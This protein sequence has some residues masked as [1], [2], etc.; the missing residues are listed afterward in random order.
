[1]LAAGA[2]DVA[3]GIE[4]AVD[5]VADHAAVAGQRRRLLDQRRG[6]RVADVGEIV[7][8]PDQALDERR[9]H[10]L[11]HEPD[12]RDRGER[13][14]QRDQVARPGRANRHPADEP[15][16]VVDGAQRVAQ[17]AALGGLERE[18]LDRVEPILDPLERRQR[19]HQPGA[20]AAC[21]HD[22]L[23]PIEHRQQRSVAA[24][25]RAFE[26]L[27]VP[28][29]HR[30]DEQAVLP[31]APADGP[32]VGEVDL[33][34]IAQIFD[35]RPGGAD[36]GRVAV[37]A[38]GVQAAG[39]QLIAQ[40][41]GGA[42][43]AEGPLVERR[44]GDAEAGD[45]GQQRHRLD[46]LRHDDLAGPQHAELLVER[47]PAVGA[48]IL[49][50]Q[51]LAGRGVE[52]SHPEEVA[53]AGCEGEQEGRLTGIEIAGVG[54]GPRRDDAGHVALDDALGLLRILDLVADGDPEAALTSRVM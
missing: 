31:L 23:G 44:H 11:E 7:Q 49:G 17:A 4:I 25:F 22:G 40:R 19:A 32:D 39:P 47:L 34:R 41:L 18:L 5:A 2:A 45:L 3:Q 21:A 24:A 54:Q 1:M 42:V 28:E 26:N 46:A 20:Q 15:L 48:G 53:G 8:F 38:E 12:A 14:P 35:Q 10:R 9:R 27:E 6:E 50:G 36:R 13:L 30:I 33:L 16:E 43:D 51:E 52:Q 29:R 37:E